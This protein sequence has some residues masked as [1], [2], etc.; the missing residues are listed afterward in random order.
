M[1]NATTPNT[2]AGWYPDPAGA[3]RS[4]WWDGTQWTEHYHDPYTGAPAQT[5]SAPAGTQPYTPW[6]WILAFLPLLSIVTLFSLNFTGYLQATM[7]GDV[8]GM[9][10]SLFTPGYFLALL[11]AFL[12]W[13]GSVLCSYLD[14]KE[15]VR[16]E[17]PRPFHW[18]F[19]FLGVTVYVIGRSVVVR[20]RTGLGIAPMWVAIAVYVAVFVAS[21]V[22]TSLMMVQMMQ[23]LPTYIP[24][25]PGY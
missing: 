4:R 25:V 5:L 1:T 17:V 11:F 8:R 19:A 10:S 23:M 3:G 2:P 13:G 6:I 20:R 7:T 18:A 24:N 12:V 16:R 14:W 15:L 9:M 22:W 21:L